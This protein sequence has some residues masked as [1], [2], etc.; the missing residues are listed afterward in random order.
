MG[1]VRM[2]GTTITEIQE[3]RAVLA[4]RCPR[5]DAVGN[6]CMIRRGAV[7][8]GQCGAEFDFKRWRR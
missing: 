3:R 8:C 2:A 4:G 7:R 5:C 6:V 1:V